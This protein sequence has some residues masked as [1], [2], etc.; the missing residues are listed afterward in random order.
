MLQSTLGKHEMAGWSCGSVTSQVLVTAHVRSIVIWELLTLSKSSV[1]VRS[2]C[3]WTLARWIQECSQTQG[4]LA[5]VSCG[6]SDSQWQGT[7]SCTSA[8][9]QGMRTCINVGLAARAAR[10]AIDMHADAF[11]AEDHRLAVQPSRRQSYPSPCGCH[12]S[13]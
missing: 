11:A 7:G 9:K 5:A 8:R 12:P 4:C 3:H 10:Q 1:Y 2:S 13:S 6:V